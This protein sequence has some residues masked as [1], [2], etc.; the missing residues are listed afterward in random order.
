MLPAE[1]LGV[2][3]LPLS[4]QIF[5][6]DQ[7][8][9]RCKAVA[10][11]I[12]RAEGVTPKHLIGKNEACFAVVSRALTWRLDPYAVACATYQTPGGQVGFYGSLC[13]AII[14][15]SGR[16]QG[17]V[18]FQHYGDWSKIANKFRIAT[19]SSGGKYP[20]SDWKPEDEV[21]LG[22]EV[23]AQ[24]KGEADRRVMRFDLI[25]AYP[26]N[27]TLWATD[28]HTQIQ[29]TA[30]RRF[31]TSTVPTLF[32]GVPFE[33]GDQDWASN[34]Q[35][36]TPPRPVAEDFTEAGQPRRRH[37]RREAAAE[38]PK[39]NGQDHEPTMGAQ[40]GPTY[41]FADPVGELHEFTDGQEAVAA[42][43]AALEGAAKNVRSLE[44]YWENGA[45]LISDLRE[46]G[47]AGAADQLN[48]QY[49]MLMD[50]AQYAATP[51]PGAETMP[52]QSEF[53][54]TENPAP[55]DELPLPRE[56]GRSEA[57][58]DVVVPAPPG[59]AANQWHMAARAALQDMVKAQRPPEDYRRFR[60]A[61]KTQLDR[62]QVELRSWFNML[63]K[64]IDQ[65]IEGGAR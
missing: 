34:L 40:V 24:I 29:Y 36:V 58:Y 46:H 21:G 30:V 39:G 51:G 4:L 53:P 38:E 15:N 8:Y 64:T 44:A 7:L 22:V 60:E 20:V 63:S 2:G 11:Y 57:P 6:N 65:Q 17:G 45:R 54:E 33:G 19:N 56:Q 26:R 35:D 9:E 61:N 37:R 1:L 32:L 18:R 13:Q 27:S 23:S 42:F 25:Q 14:E 5:F 3:S 12:A 16:L 43:A 10:S 41:F 47:H 52:Q 55:P 50:E 28:P 59:M 48:D 31:A 62:L 49:A